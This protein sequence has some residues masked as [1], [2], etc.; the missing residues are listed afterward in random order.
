MFDASVG[1]APAF[2]PEAGLLDALTYPLGGDAFVDRYY[3]RK[4][5]HFSGGGEARVAGML[6]EFLHGGDLAALAGDTPSDRIHCWVVSAAGGAG[7]GAPPPLIESVKV[8]DA[9]DAMVLHR[10]GASLYFRAPAAFEGAFVP[11]LCEDLGMAWAAYYDPLQAEPRGEV[12]TFASRAGHVTRWHWDFMENVTV[13]LAGHKRWRLRAGSVPGA[14]RGV[15]PHYALGPDVVEQQTK[16]HTLADADFVMQP[17]PSFFDGAPSVLLAPGDTFYFPPGMWHQVEAVGDSLSINLSLVT[18]SWGEYAAGAV[19]HLLM[20]DA[21]ARRMIAARPPAVPVAAPAAVVAAAPVAGTK[22]G[23]ASAGRDEAPLPGLMPLA[24]R[25]AAMLAQARGTL[26]TLQSA[27]RQLA[28]EFLVCPAMLT[29]LRADD[30][31]DAADAAVTSGDAK[32]SHG[33]A[34]SAA[35]SGLDACCDLAGCTRWH[36][37]G[38]QVVTL[39]DDGDLPAVPA[40][41][42]TTPLAVTPLALLVTEAPPPPTPTEAEGDDDDSDSS[43]GGSDSGSGSDGDSDGSSGSSEVVAF[44]PVPRRAGWHA[45][46]AHLNFGN[47]DLASTSRV[48]IQYPPSLD[49]VVSMLRRA[50]SASP[51]AAVADVSPDALLRHLPSGAVHAR[52][53]A[54]LVNAL[55]YAGVLAAVKRP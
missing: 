54:A 3:G 24:S 25:Y 41:W 35:A 42:A 29:S 48:V 46:V 1:E 30:V 38:Q 6:G 23:R 26:H 53:L 13:Q 18:L 49:A 32:R 33:A 36:H 34:T 47:D 12:E 11:A 21:A 28:P 15:T 14:V 2:V 31:P 50:T 52:R 40:D 5:V 4:C 51:G 44:E 20:R 43:D 17:P 39:L 9:K 27:V 22:R 19:R 37:G 10:V 8:D 55:L 16:V 45:V 7:A